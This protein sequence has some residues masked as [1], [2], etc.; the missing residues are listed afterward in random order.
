[1]EMLSSPTESALRGPNFY[2]FNGNI[3]YFHGNL[4]HKILRPEFPYK[5]GHNIFRFGCVH[6]TVGF[7]DWDF[8]QPKLFYIS[9]IEG[10]VSSVGRDVITH[11]FSCWKMENGAPK[12]EYVPEPL[13]QRDCCEFI[14]DGIERM[15][16]DLLKDRERIEL[17]AMTT[18]LNA[19]L[20]SPNVNGNLLS[21]EDFDHVRESVNG[22]IKKYGNNIWA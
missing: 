18:F 17:R 1:M 2:V 5:V 20:K 4:R 12:Q 19:A 7:V 21:D 10:H 22:L 15:D 8:G 11:P 9:L 3:R 16:R 6:D 13:D 14:L